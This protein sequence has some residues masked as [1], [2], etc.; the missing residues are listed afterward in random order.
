MLFELVESL[1]ELVEIC[2]FFKTILTDTV[3]FIQTETFPAESRLF[4]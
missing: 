1:M 3:Y 4:F 2:Y